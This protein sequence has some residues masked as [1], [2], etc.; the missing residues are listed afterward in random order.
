MTKRI[1][2]LVLTALM[3]FAIAGCEKADKKGGDKASSGG[4]IPP[5]NTELALPEYKIENKTIKVLS[6]SD[7]E[8]TDGSSLWAQAYKLAEEK[9]GIK[10]EK[11]MVTDTWSATTTM[12]AT[13]DPPSFVEAHKVR[14]FFPRLCSEGIFADVNTL[15][16]REDVMWKDMLKY[17]DIYSIGDK[18]Y[19]L[20]TDVFTSETLYYNKKLIKAAG[21]EDPMELYK[22]NE[23]T[24]DKLMEYIEKLS[25]DKNGDGAIDVYGIDRLNLYSGY[26]SSLGK[27]DVAIKDGKLTTDP[28]YDGTYEK[29]GNFASNLL[30]RS[31]KGYCPPL[32]NKVATATMLFSCGGYWGIKNNPTLTAQMK[33]G[34]ISLVP[35]PRHSDA[36]KYYMLGVTSGYAIPAAG[37]P[38]AAAAVLSCFRYLKYPNEA[39]LKAVSQQYAAEGWSEDVVH[40]L[41]HDQFCQPGALQEFSLTPN[42]NFASAEVSS[43]LSKLGTDVLEKQEN[44]ATVRDKYITRIKNAVDDA[45]KLISK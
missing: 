32:E 45:N 41:T 31:A 43:V 25:G 44:W 33:A 9:Y 23:W 5:A 2:A 17:N 37:N 13:G 40:F 11:Q 36:D 12:L 10:V 8:A 14:A 38:V 7:S 28:L 24:W 15:I 26:M 22:K 27:T 6:T 18:S 21:L 4:Q 35:F 19:S 29:F 42:L 3:I 1:I 16:N 30:S 20:V 34:E 39:N